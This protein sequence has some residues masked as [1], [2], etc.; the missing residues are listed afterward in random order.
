[1][2]K[3]IPGGAGLISQRKEVPSA[4]GENGPRWLNEY[5][6]N[7]ESMAYDVGSSSAELLIGDT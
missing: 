2:K 5:S 6:R 1:M 3:Y 4:S 7:H